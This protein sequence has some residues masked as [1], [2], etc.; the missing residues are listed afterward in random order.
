M[1]STP[2]SG[3]GG[4][5]YPG[6]LTYKFNASMAII[7]VV[8]VTT[9]FFMALFVLYIRRCNMVNATGWNA[10]PNAQ[11]QQGQQQQQQQ[12]RHRGLDPESLEKLPILRYSS[13]KSSKKGK[14]GPECTV[15]LLQFEENEQ[16]RLLPDCGH[17]FHADCIDMWLETH[18]TCPLC[19]RNLDQNAVSGHLQRALSAV[20]GSFRRD[21]NSNS[22]AEG[23]RDAAAE[24]E[25]EVAVAA[26][27]ERSVLREDHQPDEALD[28]SRRHDQGQAVRTLSRHSESF[29]MAVHDLELMEIREKM[30]ARSQRGLAP[31][32]V[33]IHHSNSFAG[34]APLDEPDSLPAARSPDVLRRSVSV[35]SGNLW[36]GGGESSAASRGA[37]V[38][39]FARRS[40]KWLVGGAAA[41]DVTA[42]SS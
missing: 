23:R 42:P 2:P 10:G 34:L 27:P 20:V 13:I 32:Q 22:I 38:S 30:R 31:P 11:Q 15:C 39:G 9:F 17:L 12:Q 41:K 18:S 4:M 6:D 37:A 26:D 8:L 14:A 33:V 25:V 36:S 28:A 3:P 19:R 16:V 40:L 21:P 1:S 5:F 35:G 24:V 29:K 7:V